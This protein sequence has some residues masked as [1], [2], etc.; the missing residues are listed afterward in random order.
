MRVIGGGY[1]EQG[2]MPDESPSRSFEQPKH[3]VR[4]GYALAFGAQEVTR[5][6]FKEYVDDTGR[7]VRGCT[8]YDGAWTYDSTLSWSNPGYA[9]SASHPVVCVS[10]RDAN[11]YAQWLSRKTGENYRLPSASEWEYAA[12]AAA[13][14]QPWIGKLADACSS[15][16]VADEAAAQHYAGFGVHPCNDGYVYTAP[17]GTFAP[18]AFGLSDML[19]NVFEWVQDCWHN[20]YD[21]APMDGSAWLTGEC[22]EREMRGGSWFTTPGYVRAAYRNRFG[23]NYRASSVGFR[24]V[25]DMDR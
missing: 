21:N 16:N 7:D 1:F 14:E 2:S 19:G 11:D 6:E 18:N 5:G 10:W 17:V 9:Q 25:R 4:I 22:S 8:T 24:V 13:A 20:N 3:L 23:E 15:A 12:R